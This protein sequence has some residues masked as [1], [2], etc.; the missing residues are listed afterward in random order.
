MPTPPTLKEDLRA[1]IA[2]IIEKDVDA[3]GDDVLLRDLG[4]DSMQA[5]EIISDIER[6]YQIKIA[7]SEFKNIS[8]L[9]SVH[10]FVDEKLSAG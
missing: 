3:V 6:R 7:E 10:R 8:T 5:I 9:A 2:E 1:L 4:V